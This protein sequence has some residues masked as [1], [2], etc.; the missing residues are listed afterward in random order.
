MNELI[1]AF[2]KTGFGS[3]LTMACTIVSTKILAVMLGPQWTGLS[4]LLA[5][6][7]TT[8]AG[9]ATLS[10]AS[11]IVQGA[12]ARKAGERAG[13]LA[14]VLWIL[15][16]LNGLISGLILCF[17]PV[18][19]RTVFGADDATTVGLVR[20]LVLPMIATNMVTFLTSM[21]NAYRGIGRLAVV[22][23]AG[24]VV[25]A[26]LAYPVALGVRA[27][28]PAL[29][30]LPNILAPLAMLILTASFLARPGWLQAV[31]RAFRQGIQR[32]HARHFLVFSSVT[33]V[34]GLVLT[35]SQLIVRALITRQFGLE[36]VGIFNAAWTIS[37]TY[38]TLV[39]TA[40]STYYLP[41]L[42]QI[43][44]AAARAQ[45]MQQVLRLVIV[46]LPLLIAGV[47]LFKP[48]VIRLLFADAYLP[49]ITT[50]RWM[51]I[52]DYFKVTSWVLAMPMLARAD[53]KTFFWSEII[54]FLSFLTFSAIMILHFRWVE[55]VGL[56]FMLMYIGYMIFTAMYARKFHQFIIDPYM[57][58]IWLTGLM[59][60]LLFSWLTWN[61][62]RFY[63]L[64][65]IAYAIISIVFVIFQLF[66]KGWLSI[67]DL[68]HKP[69]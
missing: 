39:V 7:V 28:N 41:S 58:S 63:L 50:M 42:S 43:D 13:Y 57:L 47:I 11:A 56:G 24:G 35:G 53:M 37:M 16:I 25:N 46:I 6:I 1:K 2:F 9:I 65:S 29:I 3:I 64:K 26:G 55:G 59:L 51:M 60:V 67:L 14:T 30:I 8:A 4:G 31:A 45:L 20:L 52:G 68:R 48:L 32:P 23:I 18:I 34:T 17:A 54:T 62:M 22:Q 21:L 36:G 10:G 40:L 44:D 49:A 19:S 5:Q 27:G 12:A 66:H 15:L 33:L 38:V 69:S 61:D